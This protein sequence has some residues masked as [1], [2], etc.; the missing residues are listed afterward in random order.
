VLDALNLEKGM[1]TTFLVLAKQNDL[2]ASMAAELQAQI[3][4]A[5]AITAVE[6]AKGHLLEARGFASPT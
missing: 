6:Q 1:S 5:K 3:G 2:N 4:M